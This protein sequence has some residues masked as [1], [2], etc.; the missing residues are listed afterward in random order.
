MHNNFGNNLRYYFH[1]QRFL[2][3]INSIS[4]PKKVWKVLAQEQDLLELDDLQQGGHHQLCH[5]SKNSSIY[6]FNL[7]IGT[8][9][10]SNAFKKI[11]F[12]VFSIEHYIICTAY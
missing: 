11:V 10:H 8:F 4:E 9:P 6:A 7:I 3:R 12:L 5:G 2:V 1:S